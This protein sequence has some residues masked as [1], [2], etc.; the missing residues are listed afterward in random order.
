MLVLLGLLIAIVM[1][2]L[3]LLMPVLW[4]RETYNEYRGSRAVTCPEN[5]RQVAVS[6]DSVHAAM[7]AFKGIPELRLLECT[8]WPERIKCGQKCIPEALKT[9]PYT[10]GE[11]Q[12]RTKRVYHLPVLIAAFAG[13]YVGAV[14]HSHYLFRAR[15]MTDLGLTPDQVKTI[16]L[17]YSPHLLSA[18]LSLLFAY[19]VA[20]LLALAGRRGMLNGLLAS[21]CLWGA[22]LLASLPSVAGLSRD[23]LLIEMGYSLLA[24]LVMGVAI[25]GLSGKLVLSTY[26]TTQAS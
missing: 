13:W 23:L 26:S 16:V 25:G 6:F 20:W 9:A 22:V 12:V 14:W 1:G 7:S 21:F 8:R 5:G 15:W 18:A 2:S 17:W 3:I 10:R 11:V 19:G 24:A 4:G